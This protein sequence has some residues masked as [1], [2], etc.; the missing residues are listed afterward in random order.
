MRQTAR[1]A[2]I[3]GASGQDGILLAQLLLTHRY[4]VWAFLQRNSPRLALLRAHAPT[5][6]VIFGD[7][8]EDRH[9]S[10]A[11]SV[12]EPDEIYNLAALSSVAKSWTR[13][14][15][16]M[17]VNALAVV[18]LLEAIRDRDARTGR[19]TRFYQ[20]SSSEMFG[21]PAEVPQTEKTAFHPRSP[22]GVAK[23]A[24]HFLTINYRESYGMFACSGIL[25]NH[26]SPLREPH[27]VTR[28][29]T[30]GVAAIAL[31]LTDRLQLGSLGVSRDW[32]Y[33]PDY[34]RAMWSMLQQ[35]KADDY[36]IATGKSHSLEDFLSA[37][38][39]CVGISDWSR[40]VMQD[41]S[42]MRPAEVVN[43]LGDATKARRQL[44]WTPTVELP[45]IVARMVAHDVDQLTR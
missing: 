14:K 1:T 28:K 22:Y 5:A 8:R 31:G 7:I 32:G 23:S 9:I 6:K 13:A 38:F 4:T 45:E 37:A 11:L 41:E 21:M 42:L 24:A 18:T 33:A 39:A 26:E 17:D 2:L 16:V 43:L 12:S 20:A 44:G 3:T 40:Y 36:V 35:P 25:Y 10:D 27:F 34:V 19:Q 15:E 30:M 29:I